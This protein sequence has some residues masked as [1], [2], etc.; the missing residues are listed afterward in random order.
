MQRSQPCICRYAS[1]LSVQLLGLRFYSI[2]VNSK[3]IV[4]AATL[5]YLQE[6][7]FCQSKGWDGDV[8][9]LHACDAR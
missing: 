3:P 6:Q 8:Q 4:L 2:P 1:V 7:G 9:P 5:S